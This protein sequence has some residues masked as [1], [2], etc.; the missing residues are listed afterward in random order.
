MK[1]YFHNYIR[2]E[3]G[4]NLGIINTD[5]QT[6]TNQRRFSL[7]QLKD[8]GFGRKSLDSVMLEEV[9]DVIDGM[10]TKKNVTM[11]STFNVAIINVL[12]Q[13]VASKRFDPNAADT[14]RMMY[15]LNMQFKTGF[16]FFSS[17][18]R[19]ILPPSEV[20]KSF[21]EMKAMMR[22]LIKEHLADVD[23]ESPRDFIDV[24]LKQIKDVGDHFDIDHLV[25]ICLDFFQ[26][27]AETTRYVHFLFLLTVKI[28]NFQLNG[29]LVLH[30]FLL[31]GMI[32][33]HLLF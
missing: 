13:I 27:G 10:I 18:L 6:W 21:F 7:K 2:G 30:D 5:G 4:K 26:A 15:L 31:K 33:F 23:Y 1:S 8:L 32:F 25:V 22:G 20:D 17:F 24:Y 19:R 28:S 14:K 12:W 11:E 9:D 3:N 16:K 29:V